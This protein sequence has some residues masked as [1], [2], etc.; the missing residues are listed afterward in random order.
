MDTVVL[1]A[2]EDGTSGAKAGLAPSA[3][4]KGARAAACNGDGG[5]H[6]A[7][8]EALAR[9]AAVDCPD[10]NPT[11]ADDPAAERGGVF[12]AEGAVTPDN[13]GAH[14]AEGAINPEVGDARFR[15]A[16]AEVD[17]RIG[18]GGARNAEAGVVLELDVPGAPI[19]LANGLDADPADT[20]EVE[21]TAGLDPGLLGA[22][23]AEVRIGDFEPRRCGEDAF[24]RD[25]DL[26]FACGETP[27]RPWR[28]RFLLP[29]FV[30]NAGFRFSFDGRLS[31]DGGVL[32]CS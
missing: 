24:S 7:E 11:A 19:P 21:A 1:I 2:V 12:D 3:G 23:A 25:G 28:P 15:D 26:D 18:G 14:D 20:G 27:L 5:A 17:I 30:S 9:F 22:R 4:L 29:R 31:N 6:D 32:G 10:R 13:G 16:I 8:A